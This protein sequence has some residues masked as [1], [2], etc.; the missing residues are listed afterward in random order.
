[1]SKW[2]RKDLYRK[3]PALLCI[4]TLAFALLTSNAAADDVG[5][6]P[7]AG[8]GG[9]SSVSFS[10]V[11]SKPA[12]GAT[13]VDANTTIWLLFNKNVVN[14]TVADNNKANIT[15]KDSAGNQIK[16]EVT[17][18]DDQVEPEFRREMVV[19]PANP[20]H[21]GSKY[22]LTVGSAVMAKNGDS[23]GKDYTIAFTTADKTENKSGAVKTAVDAQHK[24]DSSEAD[25]KAATETAATAAAATATQLSLTKNGDMQDSGVISSNSDKEASTSGPRSPEALMI[26]MAAGIIILAAAVLAIFFIRK[27]KKQQ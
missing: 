14:M 7:E 10:L 1:M 17:M 15:L 5:T 13:E 23:L 24:K 19:V 26:K 6:A 20:L 4:L 9:G 25:L 3:L 2:K 18:K 8:S 21:G 27:R 22:I 12:D 11:E 16:A